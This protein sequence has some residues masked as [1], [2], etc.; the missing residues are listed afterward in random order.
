M[1]PTIVP[2]ERIQL[3]NAIGFGIFYSY[4]TTAVMPDLIFKA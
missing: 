4:G 2:A 1:L 3:S